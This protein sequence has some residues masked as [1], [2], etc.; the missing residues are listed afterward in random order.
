MRSL[1]S[2]L[3]TDCEEL[4]C[5]ANPR[6]LISLRC[7]EIKKCPKLIFTPPLNP[8]IGVSSLFWLCIDN[9]SLLSQSHLHGL[10]SVE[11]L[12][13]CDL[14]QLRSFGEAGPHWSD[15]L[16]SLRH[17]KISN[18]VGLKFLPEEI[19]EF[20]NLES[21]LIENCPEITSLPM[22]GFPASLKKME[23][24]GSNP[25]LRGQCQTEEGKEWCK[26]SHIPYVR[27]W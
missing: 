20:S 5:L 2:L 10:K 18:C 1:I 11:E 26:I 4:A 21:L 27:M 22:K 6:D 16:S 25:V 15:H 17:L 9:V 7:L 19:A 8:V 13:I 24:W 12:F 23:I 14:P 3:I